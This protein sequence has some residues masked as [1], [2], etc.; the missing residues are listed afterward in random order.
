M[1]VLLMALALGMDSFSLSIGLGCQGLKAGRAWLLT[2]LVG[3]FHILFPL[4]GLWLGQQVGM[5]LGNWAIYLGAS[6][7]IVLGLKM[8]LEARTQG[9]ASCQE[10]TGWQI[11]LLPMVVSLDALTVGFSLGAFGVH[12]LGLVV[13]FG[14][15]AAFMTRLGV[16]LGDRL[17]MFFHKTGY[18]A[19]AILMGLGLWGLFFS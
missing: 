2:S 9:G 19:G 15:V 14:L 6:I 4:L 7:L 5:Y 17:G 16:F 10:F 13:V 18:L 11:V 1:E 3:L 12:F 8:I